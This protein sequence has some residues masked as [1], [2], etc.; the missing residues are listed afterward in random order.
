MVPGRDRVLEFLRQY[1]WASG[2]PGFDGTGD[3]NVKADDS[4]FSSHTTGARS[5]ITGA[6]L[7]RRRVAQLAGGLPSLPLAR[8]YA[9]ISVTDR[10][11]G[12]VT[13]IDPHGE[14]FEATFVPAGADGPVLT[15]EFLVDEVDEDDRE[16]IRHG[17][18]FYA[19]AG[20]LRISDT[21]WQATSAIRFRRV[22]PTRS[23]D[24]DDAR[25]YALKVRQRLGLA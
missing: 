16:L 17:A 6:V 20:R 22:P 13:N 24:L 2:G 15:A 4:L 19:L 8:P 5:P 3:T 11:D 23:D 18:L 9:E 1:E 25:E 12:V 7:A 14:F 21:R 10:W